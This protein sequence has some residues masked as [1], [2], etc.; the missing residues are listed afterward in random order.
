LQAGFGELNT[1]GHR[2]KMTAQLEF[3]PNTSKQE[4]I[5]GD[6]LEVMR[7]MAE[8][9]ID[10]IVTDSPYGISFM[11]KGW[12]RGIPSIEYWQEMLRIVKP[13]GHLCA[14]GL[15]RMMHRLISVIEDAGWEIRDLIMHLF[16]QGFPK[17]HNFGRKLNED[18]HGYGT[19]LK[20]SWEGWTLAMKPIE[21][22]YIENAEKWGVAGINV[23]ASRISVSEKDPNHR[24]NPTPN[25]Y[26][27][28]FA[29]IGGKTSGIIGKNEGRWPSN[30]I[31]SEES[32]A[33]LD[34]MTG[35]SKSTGGQS[36]NALRS[37][38]TIFGTGKDN[39]IKKDPGY[40][41]V[42]GAS[43]FFY[44]AKASSRERNRGLEGLPL[45]EHYTEANPQ[46]D[47]DNRKQNLVA[48]H[49]PT[50]KPIALMKY[51]LKLLAP[52][53]CPV[54]LDPF[55]GSGS[56]LVAAKE[57]GIS[58]IGIEKEEEYCEIARKRVEGA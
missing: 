2:G 15:P 18:W 10:F 24:Q 45:K 51:I 13:G 40:G 33:E 54:C 21:K 49:H 46:P 9:S 29:N 50:V 1:A 8:N 19:A 55:A 44:C 36:N 6:C 30:I 56:T 5:Q 42:G 17:S 23:D 7:G 43:R 34:Q 25:N 14:A 32:A 58:C 26:T 28:M 38:Q 22:T 39:L 31:L 57:L 16:G 35:V 41:D 11:S 48:N 47:R 53:G 27:S 20:P 37:D 3:F 4:V 12:D 52:P